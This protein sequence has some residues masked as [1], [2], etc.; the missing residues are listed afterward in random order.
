MQ[1]LHVRS[2]VGKCVP[3]QTPSGTREEG[4]Y[5]LGESAPVVDGVPVLPCILWF[6]CFLERWCLVDIPD[7]PPVVSMEDVPLAWLPLLLLPDWP[8]DEPP[9]WL[10]VL[11]PD[12][13]VE[14]PPD[15]PPVDPLD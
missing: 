9:D 4:L 3:A 15:W 7:W 10:P 13:P 11:L 12:L 8:V 2:W 5:C 14:V 1:E 6:L